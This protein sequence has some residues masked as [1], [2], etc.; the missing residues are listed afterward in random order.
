[1]N[2]KALEYER[3]FKFYDYNSELL[4]EI[5]KDDVVISKSIQARKWKIKTST[6]YRGSINW[7]C[8]EDIILHF[9]PR[10]DWQQ[11]SPT[12][13]TGKLLLCSKGKFHE[14]DSHNMSLPLSVSGEYDI[15]VNSESFLLTSGTTQVEYK[16]SIN[17]TSLVVHVTQPEECDIVDTTDFTDKKEDTGGHDILHCQ[18]C[19]TAMRPSGCFDG[20]SRKWKISSTTLSHNTTDHW[21]TAGYHNSINWI[22]GADILLHFVLRNGRILLNSKSS[23]GL[24]ISISD[25]NSSIKSIG[26][27]SRA[28]E[29]FLEPST[30]GQYEVSVDRTGFLI[31]AG[32]TQYLFKHRLELDSTL[33]VHLVVPG[34]YHIVETTKD[35]SGPSDIEELYENFHQSTIVSLPEAK[36]CVD[37]AMSGLIKLNAICV[38]KAQF[39]TGHYD[40]LVVTDSA[41]LVAAVRE[42]D[43]KAANRM[44]KHLHATMSYPGRGVLRGLSTEDAKRFGAGN[45]FPGWD[46][47]LLLIK[48]IHINGFSSAAASIW[49]IDTPAKFDGPTTGSP[50]HLTFFGGVD[51]GRAM[52]GCP[53]EQRNPFMRVFEVYESAH[54]KATSIALKSQKSDYANLKWHFERL[55][56]HSRIIDDILVHWVVRFQSFLRRWFAKLL[57]G[58]MHI[59]RD[60]LTLVGRMS[61]AKQEA[62]SYM[63]RKWKAWKAWHQELLD[64]HWEDY[65]YGY[66]C[67]YW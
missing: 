14:W 67:D 45:G 28:G 3:E 57:V 55:D 51:A 56:R 52:V 16:H 60:L 64:Q 2:I 44:Q 8:E 15:S 63:V 35:T 11:I 41:P 9:N 46:G 59:K 6:N 19:L 20:K 38:L 12:P 61:P 32:A 7:I 29:E 4:Y 37:V 54:M 1:M 53:L 49:G 40:S 24:P 39:S 23:N 22:C 25:R 50:Y 47:V 34:G 18:S 17:F 27:W 58:R 48:E 65:A 66:E 33:E 5:E 43:A 62:F 42:V 36:T 13:G 30:D 10:P 21:P 31:T 26:G